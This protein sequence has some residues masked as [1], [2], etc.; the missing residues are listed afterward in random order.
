V[1]REWKPGDVAMVVCGDERERPATY[2]TDLRRGPYWQFR[3]GQLRDAA[4]SDAR[5][6]VVIDS[7]D[8]EEVER[9]VS[10]LEDLTGHANGLVAVHMAGALREFAD[11][12]PPCGA[13]LCLGK[14]GALYRCSE[15]EGHEGPHVDGTCVWTAQP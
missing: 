2:C 8:A 15:A 11:P 10:R 7:E 1:S 12:K 9:L 13:S 6:L 4:I 14:D 3:D 5:P